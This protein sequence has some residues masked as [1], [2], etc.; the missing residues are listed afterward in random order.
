LNGNRFSWTFLCVT[1]T[2]SALFA[3][4]VLSTASASQTHRL[5]KGESLA[6][7]A[8]QYRVS[9]QDIASANHLSDIDNLREGHTLT[10]PDPPKRK[11]LK[12]WLHQ[13]A[14]AKGDRT[15]IRLGPGADYRRMDFCDMGASLVITAEQE[16]WAQVALPDG[17]TGWIRK[18]LID[19]SGKHRSSG[20]VAQESSHKSG[21]GGHMP[22]H[23]HMAAIS[24][25]R[26]GRRKARHTAGKTVVIARKHHETQ[27]PRH[28]AHSKRHHSTHEVHVAQ[29]PRHSRHHP[30]HIA[31]NSRHHG[32]SYR[33]HYVAEAS[34]P[35]AGSD[36]V[37]TA[38]A[39]RG[40][41]YR[42]G[43][44]GRGGF[45]CSGFTSYLYSH[46]GVSLPHSARGQ[47]AHGQKV[48]RSEMKPG[49]L[50]FFHTVTSGISHVGMYVGNGRFVHASSRRS[51]GVRVDSLES[52]YY[53][54][55]FRGARR[56]KK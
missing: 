50:V 21:S 52:G 42:Y 3:S 36:I 8:R 4:C 51:G 20:A 46:K 33:T 45:D 38:Y 14:V 2:T 37:R 35:E 55:A 26:A 43:G 13:A 40:T 44:A 54:G 28:S 56:V 10:I 5:K 49:D 18:D 16:G 48:G 22:K 11:M 25:D 9:V 1:A 47:F 53:K 27:Y 12:P 32:R 23:P 24:D 7:L 15:S 19:F 29:S 34:M 39:Y 41:P 30:I 6:S 31:S 17:R